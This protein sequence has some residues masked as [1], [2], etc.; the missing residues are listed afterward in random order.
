MSA[1]LRFHT[2]LVLITALSGAVALAGATTLRG[3][4]VGPSGSVIRIAPCEMSL[5][6]Q[7]AG[8]SAG[9]HPSTDVHNP[10][11]SLRGRPLCGLR[12]GTG[13]TEKGPR[14]AVGGRLYDPRS[15]RTYSATME[16]DG[17]RLELRGF[18]GV[19]LFGRTETWRRADRI[20]PSCG[21]E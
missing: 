2:G 14:R 15:G 12:I 17:D 11:P 9:P 5:C 13:F 19:R 10:D 20:P 7:I 16:A 1:T 8:L 18:I 4:W 21:S 6:V 3:Y